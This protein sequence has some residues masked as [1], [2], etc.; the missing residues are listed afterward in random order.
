MKKILITIICTLG[1]Q[2]S[3]FGQKFI[4][5][6]EFE[7][8]KLEYSD[9]IKLQSENKKF[10]GYMSIFIMN[11]KGDK[12]KEIKVFG[13]SYENDAT[14]Q[15][16]KTSSFSNVK[17]IIK[18]SISECACN[19]N[20]SIYYWLIT[21]QNEWSPLPTIELDDYEFEM[22]YKDYVFSKK[23]KDIIQLKEYQD[24]RIDKKLYT[25]ENIRR[26]SEKVIKTLLWNGKKI[27]EK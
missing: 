13:E 6:N 21:N 5:S 3:G 19:C 10:D 27:K 20:T 16:L 22:K 2:I 7:L 26:K 8:T 9:F 12:F 1:I 15:E 14:V 25:I 24:E 11:K 17:K 4:A 23:Y 18:I